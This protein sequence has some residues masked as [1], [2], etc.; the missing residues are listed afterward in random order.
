MCNLSQPTTTSLHFRMLKNCNKWAWSENNGSR[1]ASRREFKRVS[2]SRRVIRVHC[3]HAI[4]F[5]KNMVRRINSCIPYIGAL[6]AA[7]QQWWCCSIIKL[8]NEH[9]FYLWRNGFGSPR[10]KWGSS[11]ICFTTDGALSLL[12]PSVL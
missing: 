3:S 11:V 2:L 1:A 9:S 4:H 6:S 8:W 10:K 7:P 5:F 12:E